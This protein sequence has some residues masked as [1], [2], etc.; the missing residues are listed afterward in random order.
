MPKP[1]NLERELETESTVRFKLFRGKQVPLCDYH[2][3]C[4]NKAY[5]EIY[6]SLM[7][8]E[9]KKERRKLGWSYRCRTHFRHEN[10]KFGGDLPYC[11]AN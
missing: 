9:Q 11:L 1:S 4:E 7:E 2:G 10:K 3:A 8:V 6:P 5:A